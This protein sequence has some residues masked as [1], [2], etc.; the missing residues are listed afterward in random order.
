MAGEVPAGARQRPRPLRPPTPTKQEKDG[1]QAGV[2][3]AGSSA[4]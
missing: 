3:A 2:G 1:A 4:T